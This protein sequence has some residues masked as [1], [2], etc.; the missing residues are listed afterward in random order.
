[1]EQKGFTLIE[2]LI[3]IALIAILAVAI[4]SAI[5]PVEQMKK[6][7]DSA[8]KADTSELL[9]AYERYYST[10]GCYPWQGGAGTDCPSSLGDIT[11]AANPSFGSGGNSSN[12]V[13]SNELK[14]QFTARTS[15]SKTELWISTNNMLASV[16]FEPESQSWRQK[17]G[18]ETRDRMNSTS[19]TC[20]GSYLSGSC[21]VCVPQ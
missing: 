7:R 2:L 18:G 16:C 5:N 6:A 1:M 4:L 17:G 11:T 13:T 8:R 15:I 3:V 10:Y 19:R 14:P 12:L 9:H 20:T 21:Y